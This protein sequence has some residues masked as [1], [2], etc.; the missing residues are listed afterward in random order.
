M[1]STAVTFVLFFTT[2]GNSRLIHEFL[3]WQAISDTK[4]CLAFKSNLPSPHS[5]SHFV[6]GSDSLSYNEK[7]GET[8]VN[9]SHTGSPLILRLSIKS[10]KRQLAVTEQ[11]TGIYVT[12]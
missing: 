3:Q 9:R 4:V 10:K 1:T 12:H 11:W 5:S 2:L 7:V 8:E 6:F